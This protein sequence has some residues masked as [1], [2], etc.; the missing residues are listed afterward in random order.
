[1]QGLVVVDFLGDGDDECLAALK[2]GSEG[3]GDVGFLLEDEGGEKR[4]DLG[5]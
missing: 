1:M 5:G 3:W 4:G 2:G